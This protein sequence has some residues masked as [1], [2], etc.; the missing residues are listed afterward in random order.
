MIVIC[1]TV[2]QPIMVSMTNINPRT[3]EDPEAF[4]LLIGGG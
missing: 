4:C 3:A 1:V 2:C